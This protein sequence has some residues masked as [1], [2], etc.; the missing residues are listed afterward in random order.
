MKIGSEGK[1]GPL[2]SQIATASY[3][4][5]M[6]PKWISTASTSYDFGQSRSVGQAFTITRVG[7]WLLFHLGGNVDVSK[8]NVGFQFSVEPRLG[9]GALNTS[10]FN[11]MMGNSSQPP[12]QSRF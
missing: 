5:I 9:R 10:K 3:S 8:N 7:E 6:S 4:Y 1:G 2:D 11:S 12:S